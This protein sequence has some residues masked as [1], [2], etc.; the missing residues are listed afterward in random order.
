MRQTFKGLV[1]NPQFPALDLVPDAVGMRAGATDFDS[2]LAAPP[3][4]IPFPINN[5]DGRAF[6]GHV[7]ALFGRVC[8]CSDL[9]GYHIGISHTSPIGQD[10]RGREPVLDAGVWDKSCHSTKQGYGSL[11]YREYSGAVTLQYCDKCVH[12]GTCPKKTTMMVAQRRYRNAS[13]AGGKGCFMMA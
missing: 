2:R 12:P 13:T 3:E 5:L 6:I 1:L 7:H 4:G 10:R 9:I 11:G 8:P